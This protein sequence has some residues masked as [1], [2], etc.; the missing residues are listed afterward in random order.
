MSNTE[1][2]LIRCKLCDFQIMIVFARHRKAHHPPFQRR[3]TVFYI[4]SQLVSHENKFQIQPPHLSRALLCKSSGN[5]YFRVRNMG[6][7]KN[8]GGSSPY[9][10]N[11]KTS[12]IVQVLPPAAVVEP[13]I[14][15]WARTGLVFVALSIFSHQCWKKPKAQQTPLWTKI[16][17]ILTS[18][19]LF[20]TTLAIGGDRQVWRPYPGQH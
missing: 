12:C 6:W 13:C 17:T 19:K 7:G 4:K 16:C 1:S 11:L 20:L 2:S 14:K 5:K 9:H 18:R 10:S 3:K 8:R 15:I